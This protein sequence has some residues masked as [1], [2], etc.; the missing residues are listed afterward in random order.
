MPGGA[1]FGDFCCEL[2]AAAD[3]RRAYTHEDCEKVLLY[4]RLKGKRT[5]RAARE[6]SLAATRTR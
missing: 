1:P 4:Q 5:Y 3:K 6:S 2:D